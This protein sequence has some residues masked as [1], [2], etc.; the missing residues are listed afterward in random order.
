MV[1]TGNVLSR[2]DVVLIARKEGVHLV[3]RAFRKSLRTYGVALVLVGILPVLEFRHELVGETVPARF[4]ELREVGENDVKGV[5]R[6]VSLLTTSSVWRFTQSI[7]NSG[8][9]LMRSSL[10]LRIFPGSKFLMAEGSTLTSKFGSC[11]LIIPIPTTGEDP[12][13]LGPAEM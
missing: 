1:E 9:A 4:V 13:P 3:G 7:M 11:P 2:V 8:N 12:A 6:L 5:G 10:I